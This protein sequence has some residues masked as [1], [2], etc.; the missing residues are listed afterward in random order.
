M[1]GGEPS[2]A[3]PRRGNNADERRRQI[4]DEAARLFDTAGYT[5][6][7][8]DDIAKTVGIAKPTLYHYFR[9]KDE[10]LYGI[11][12]TFLDVL[13]DRHD[14][15]LHAGLDSRQLLLET[16]SDI[17]ELMETHRG[18]VRAL[19]EHHREL[20]PDKWAEI[21]DKRDRYEAMVRKV[22]EDGI[23]RGELRD[24]DPQLATLALLGMCNWAYQWY[25]K[26]GSM[27]PRE[28]A[29]CFW[30]LIFFGFQQRDGEIESDDAPEKGR[31]RAARR[32]G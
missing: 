20:P 23:A 11:Y 5:H 25:R 2:P 18:H 14:A 9:S 32:S 16:M 12:T 21:R 31:T 3:K 22:I 30:N 13:I 28:I 17:L 7:N 26:A 29:Y 24:I 15:R 1:N 19:F 4:V 8:M 27:R 10:I 6:V